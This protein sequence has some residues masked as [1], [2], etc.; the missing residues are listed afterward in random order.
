MESGALRTRTGRRYKA[1]SIDTARTQPKHLRAEFGERAPRSI[2]RVEAEDTRACRRQRLPMVVQ[3]M[4]DL[5]RARARLGLDFYAAI[6]HY[7]CWYMKVRLGLPDAVIAA[8]AGWSESSVT[9]M[10]RTYAHA[11]DE[12]RLDEIAVA[13]ANSDAGRDAAVARSRS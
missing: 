3:F 4:N 12:R 5:Y 2:T 8:Q 6:K 11:V 10:V 7:G 1:S 9:E 13:F